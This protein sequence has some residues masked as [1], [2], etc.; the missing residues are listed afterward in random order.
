MSDL[1]Q[2][3][4]ISGNDTVASLVASSYYRTRWRPRHTFGR[5]TFSPVISSSKN[6]FILQY[7]R[8]RVVAFHDECPHH[9]VGHPCCLPAA[10]LTA[11]PLQN[12]LALARS[13]FRYLQFTD[14]KHIVILGSGDDCP[15]EGKVELTERAWEVFSTHLFLVTVGHRDGTYPLVSEYFTKSLTTCHQK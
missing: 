13:T 8:R 1:S 14:E 3:L 5:T 15:W 11:P 6:F 10:S 2:I 7:G 9:S 4:H 12:V